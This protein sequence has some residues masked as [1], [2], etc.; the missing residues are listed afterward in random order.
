AHTPDRV[1]LRYLFAFTAVVAL[2]TRGIFRE[3]GVSG[4]ELQ[5]LQDAWTKAVILHVTLWSRPYA[6]DGL[7]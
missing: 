7:W 5:R 4:Q 6:G 1:P 2:T 3:H